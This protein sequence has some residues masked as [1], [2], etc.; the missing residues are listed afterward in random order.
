MHLPNLLELKLSLLN[1][2]I[3][4]YVPQG[5][6]AIQLLRRLRAPKLDSLRLTHPQSN[7]DL[8]VALNFVMASRRLPS[9]HTITSLDIDGL[10]PLLKQLPLLQH[11]GISTDLVD[12][13]EPRMIFNVVALL[14]ALQW[15]LATNHPIE[16]AREA[17]HTNI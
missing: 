1:V 13:M 11:F 6:V 16:D 15:T 14:V 3:L 5:P 7:D 8:L 12:D 9:G 2:E 10:V 4:N 17:S